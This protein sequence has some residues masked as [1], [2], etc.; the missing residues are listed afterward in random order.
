MEKSRL[1]MK[2]Q[3]LVVDRE[4][5]TLIGLNEAIVLQQIEYWTNIKELADVRKHKTSNEHFIDGYYWTYNSLEEWTKEFPFWSYDTVKRT[6]KKLRDKNLVVT[7]VYNEKCYD[8]TLWYRANHEALIKLENDIS[9]ICT[10][11]ENSNIDE[12]KTSEPLEIDNSAKCPNG[13]VQNALIQKGKMP[14]PIP[15]TTTKNSNSSC[16]SKHNNELTDMFEE[17]I[18]T[19][20]GI[21]KSEF[22]IYCS[23]YDNDFIIAILKYC[24]KR[25]AKT[26]DYFETVINFAIQNHVITAE[27][28]VYSVEKNKSD[29]EKKR[30]ITKKSNT[31]SSNGL[32]FNN[33]KAREYDYDN[34]EKKLLG[35]DNDDECMSNFNIKDNIPSTKFD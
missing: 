34:L 5:A 6:L 15:K 26:Y 33:F 7:G 28:F 22:I 8:R 12:E 10:N 2:G 16:S 35:W 13:L 3:P 23:E 1:L 9:A 4:L 17:N 14:Q 24:C 29:R 30:N 27:D 32:R 11:E 20:K 18:C 25:N 19:L 21:S 31:K